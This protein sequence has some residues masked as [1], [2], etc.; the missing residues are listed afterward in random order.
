MIS[1]VAF[2]RLPNDALSAPHA[3]MP[4][5]ALHQ[6]AYTSA[7][8]SVNDWPVRGSMPVMSDASSESR[9]AMAAATSSGWP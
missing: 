8:W 9:N 5:A 4:F 3:S 6:P 7:E 2:Q 1:A